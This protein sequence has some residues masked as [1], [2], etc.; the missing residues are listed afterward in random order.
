MKFKIFTVKLETDCD[1]FFEKEQKKC[2]L[3][4]FA[5]LW[6]KKV[7]FFS[8]F[9]QKVHFITLSLSLSTFQ[10]RHHFFNP[11][12]YYFPPKVNNIFQIFFLNCDGYT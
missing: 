1:H 4:S 12:T 11:P 10:P 5:S 6:M 7:T 2:S 8:F 9:L 3:Y